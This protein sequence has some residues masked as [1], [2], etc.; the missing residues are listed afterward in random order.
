M[1]RG[2]TGAVGLGLGAGVLSTGGMG[3][4]TSFLG[5][6]AADA[7]SLGDL[8]VQLQWIENYNW[9]GMYIAQSRGYYKAAG[10]DV[11]FVPGGP[12]VVPETNVLAG[13]SQVGLSSA[14]A[15]AEA[16]LKGAPFK[17]FGTQ[18]QKNPFGIMSLASDPVT[19]PKGLI[20]RTVGVST[21]NQPELDAFLSLNKIDPSKIKTV[22]LGDSSAPDF[23][24]GQITAS[25]DFFDGPAELEQVGKKPYFFSLS[26][27]GYSIS[28]DSYFALQKTIDT[29]ADKLMALLE[30]DS[31]GWAAQIKD[32][33]EGATLGV[34]VYGKTNGLVLAQ[35]ITGA[36]LQNTLIH[37]ANTNK[38][39]LLS[40]SPPLQEQ[41]IASLAAGG[42][43]IT[44]AK[45]FDDSIVAE[46]YKK[47][48]GLKTTV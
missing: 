25:L 35:E 18:Y 8:S 1:Q 22:P 48:P 32:P 39:G 11:T 2:L 21:E 4:L 3:S 14:D 27:F 10:L 29:E 42:I 23:V 13:K 16:I 5:G 41:N 33:S 26:D 46:L 24:S 30:A 44:A 47:H 36:T 38:Y 28:S 31:R 43:K 6:A 17:I 7:A 15:I 19:S 9:S 34:K 45:L 37:D 20:G 12:S 40:V